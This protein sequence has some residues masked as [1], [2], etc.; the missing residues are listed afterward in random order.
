LYTQYIAG[1]VIALQAVWA[2]LT[3]PGRR[4]QILFAN[5][6]VALLF[7]PMVPGIGDNT[8]YLLAI[9]LLHPL[10]IENVSIDPL[11]LAV[12]HPYIPFDQVPGLISLTLTGTAAAIIAIASWRP[13]VLGSE[14]V[15]PRSWRAEGTVSLASLGWL[16]VSLTAGILLVT[17][18]YSAMAD[19]SIWEPRTLITTVPYACVL[20]G[21]AASTVQGRPGLVATAALVL[22]A[23]LGSV[24]MLISYP[25]P[26]IR[27]AAEAIESRAAPG[28]PVVEWELGALPQQEDLAI[29]LDARFPIIRPTTPAAWP[30]GT[31]VYTVVNGF[32]I[33]PRYAKELQQR[34][35]R[36]AADAG[37]PLLQTLHFQGF[38]EVTVKRYGPI[39]A[40]G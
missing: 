34:M 22:A 21:I 10:T 39:G 1:I 32:Q 8:A 13:G 40:R 33:A 11:R 6:V 14:P 37:A 24:R 35:D 25:R 31:E 3:Q 16:L 5:A 2:L 19:N 26:D 7:L 36:I 17:L 23:L 20:V 38:P 29:Y 18:L 27:A 4:R 28:T 12:G 15:A 30:Q 9:E